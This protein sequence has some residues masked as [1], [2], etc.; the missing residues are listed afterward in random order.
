MMT[1]STR[2]GR[3]QL[4][5]AVSGF[6]LAGLLVWALVRVVQ[7]R[8][9]A[10]EPFI[11]EE[12]PAAACPVDKP[13]K[14]VAER[15]RNITQYLASKYKVPKDEA[16]QYVNLAWREAARHPGVEP[17]LILAVIQ[18][19][20]SLRRKVVSGYGAEGLM[21]VVRREHAEKLGNK[22]SLFDP[23]VNIRV[24]AQILEQYIKETNG[25][26]EPALVRYSGN[27]KGYADFVM[28]EKKV[29]QDI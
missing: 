21:Q 1:F 29:L 16:N 6:V 20:S 4:F 22:E 3:G 27:A 13:M 28:H 11:I 10:F 24:G 17:E 7:P 14:S 8:P 19:E 2:S 23:H 25:D 26:E 12:L 18:K 5:I 15:K 9:P